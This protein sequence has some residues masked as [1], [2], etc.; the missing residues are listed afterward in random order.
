MVAFKFVDIADVQPKK[1][2]QPLYLET[3]STCGVTEKEGEREREITNREGVWLK[4]S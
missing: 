2:N 4:R 3:A 1:N